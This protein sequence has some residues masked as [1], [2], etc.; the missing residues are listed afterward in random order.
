MGEGNVDVFLRY[1]HLLKAEYE[2]W[3]RYSD[4]ALIKAANKHIFNNAELE[5]HHGLIPVGFL[6]ETAAPM[7]KNI[8]NIVAQSFFTVCMPDFV[9]NE[10]Q[11]L[12]KN[13]EYRF[14]TKIREMVDGGWKK[15]LSP[16][17]HEK[18][19]EDQEVTGF[20]ETD[21]RISGVKILDKKTNPPKEYSLDTLLSFME[22]PKDEAGGRKLAGLGTPATRGE[23][24]GTLF[25]REYITE[26]KKKLFVTPK[27]QFVL[28]Q[29]KKD[30]ELGKIA[31]VSQTTDWEQQ[32]NDNPEIF[33]KSITEFIKRS[34]K[35]ELKETYQQESPGLCPICKKPV[36]EGK[37]SFYCSGY[38]K[39][40]DGCKFAI[41]KEI[42]GAKITITD[43]K[44]ILE[45][46]PITARNFS[47][48]AGKKFQASLGMDNQGKINFIFL[49]KKEKGHRGKRKKHEK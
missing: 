40:G 7:E 49:P 39:E 14:Q 38:K 21:C 29:L 17:E 1:F 27:G 47:S 28:D 10:K 48:K 11:L 24:I 31:D 18:A 5:D 16:E 22:N 12:I 41:W 23:I 43:A 4:E 6:P 13:G 30:K 45:G 15:S 25:K 34:I 8:F 37:R 42:A 46:K 20:D 35:K 36:Y 33:E 26:E 3:S 44:E 9:Y 2:N 32:L 19:D